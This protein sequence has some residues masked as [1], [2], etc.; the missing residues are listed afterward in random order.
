METILWG[1]VFVMLGI[2]TILLITVT[3]FLIR[4]MKD[5][6]KD[7]PKVAI[8][9]PVKAVKGHKAQK[10]AKKE[11]DRIET[12]LANISNYDGTDSNQMDVPRG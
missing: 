9:S 4:L 8:P 1:F 2:M 12:I 5:I 7:L 10:E 3:V 11:L 6:S